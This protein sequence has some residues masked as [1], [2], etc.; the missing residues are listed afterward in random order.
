MPLL[1]PLV[2]LSDTEEFSALLSRLIDGVEGKEP[3]SDLD[4]AQ[5][6]FLTEIGW[7]SD[8]VGSGIDFA[9]NIRDE[10][11]APLLRSIQRKIVTPERF[12]LLRDNAYRVTR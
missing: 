3:L 7:A 6:L 1:T 12:A 4:W 2:G 8:V 9:T 10:K 5:A 11:A